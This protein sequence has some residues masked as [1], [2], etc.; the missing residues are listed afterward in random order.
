MFTEE[1]LLKLVKVARHAVDSPKVLIKA[2]NQGAWNTFEP[3]VVLVEAMH[4]QPNMKL[5]AFDFLLDGAK[6]KRSVEYVIGR[7]LKWALDLN[8]KRKGK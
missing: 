8:L 6:D 3:A 1:E 2:Y 4:K 5:L 7:S